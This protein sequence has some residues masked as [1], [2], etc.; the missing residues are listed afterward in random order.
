MGA[1]I[2]AAGRAGRLDGLPVALVKRFNA[3]GGYPSIDEAGQP[4][5]IEWVSDK[6]FGYSPGVWARGSVQE[7]LGHIE[8]LN[9]EAVKARGS[10]NLFQEAYGQRIKYLERE[11]ARDGYALNQDSKLDFEKFVTSNPT[12]HKGNLVLIDNG[13]LRASWKN[14]RGEH[15]GLQ[16]LG[17]GMAQYVIFKRRNQQQVIS[18]VAGRDSLEGIDGQLGAFELQPLIFE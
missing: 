8:N 1:E 11:A 7:S 2:A 13:N 14:G 18:R 15:L 17:G 9:N 4:P 5:R 6:Q 12:I 3:E 16:F 10:S